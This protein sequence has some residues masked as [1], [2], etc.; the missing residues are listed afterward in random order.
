[1]K[2]TLLTS[3][4]L[5]SLALT[6]CTDSDSAGSSSVSSSNATV[7]G[8]ANKGIVKNGQVTLCE[9]SKANLDTESCADSIIK[10]GETNDLGRFNISDVPKDESILMVLSPIK[11]DNGNIITQMKCDYQTCL[12]NGK[13]FGEFFDVKESFK[14]TAI[15][16]SNSDAVTANITPIS[17]TIT[18]RVKSLNQLDKVEISTIDAGEKL[19]A[20]ALGLSSETIREKGGVDITDPEKVKQ[21]V[22]AG[23]SE[24]VFISQINAV[25]GEELLKKQANDKAYDVINE[26]KDGDRV[27]KQKR[28]TILD[29]TETI[30]EKIVKKIK[31]ENVDIDATVFDKIKK[32]KKDEQ[33][34]LDNEVLDSIES[35]SLVA[36][37]SLV[38]KIRTVLDASQEDGKLSLAF[39]NFENDLSQIDPLVEDDTNTA[40]ERL[41]DGLLAVV[42][43]MDP[44]TSNE[45]S[46]YEV[47]V[48]ETTQTYKIK[49]D[50]LELIVRGTLDIDYNHLE[51]EPCTSDIDQ[52]EVSCEKWTE[53]E[54]INSNI[55]IVSFR[56]QESDV[57]LSS[58]GDTEN[59]GRLVVQDLNFSSESNYQDGISSTDSQNGNWQELTGQEH[60]SSTSEDNSLRD[61]KVDLNNVRLRTMDLVN[62]VTFTGNITLDAKDVRESIDKNSQSQFEADADD[63]SIYE[64]EYQSQK[65]SEFTAAAINTTFDGRLETT[66]ATLSAK[67]AVELNNPNGIVYFEQTSE[68]WRHWGEKLDV[69]EYAYSNSQSS[70]SDSGLST[71][72]DNDGNYVA[73]DR[74]N[75]LRGSITASLS[76]V[77]DKDKDQQQ[78][79][80]LSATVT[81]PSLLRYDVSSEIKYNENEL[82]LTT[83][84]DPE[85]DDPTKIVITDDNATMT[86]YENEEGQT[87][88]EITVKG[89]AV[90][91]IEEPKNDVILVNYA[92][93][94]DKFELN[95]LF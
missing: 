17:D 91:K 36:A 20:N 14:L 55:T 53:D 43:K 6:G 58:G 67:L 84:I 77:L 30:N 61:I 34:K 19:V 45:L 68:I 60:T 50:N 48:D 92:L 26:I 28:D 94:N 32:E 8:T 5:A 27:S 12:D 64:D 52:K 62:G 69:N 87:A 86:L 24:D 88:G 40:I 11:D 46:K 85:S 80:R 18:K 9:A 83:L 51:N 41:L 71:G 3:A 33:I 57:I 66:T 31:E 59:A 93:G 47:A 2:K 76:T 63:S 22:D 42:N 74:N 44:D 29:K 81:R 82:D 35:D 7:S 10:Q 65:E 39:N 13:E 56:S 16:S 25:I 15:I 1:M 72:M 73:E 90:A 49:T 4:I 95:T 79:A 23:D 54:T 70:D 38:T 37:K 21:A 89:K 78:E 75:Y